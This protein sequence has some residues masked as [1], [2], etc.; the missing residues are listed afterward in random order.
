M[1]KEKVGFIF[2]CGRDGADYQVCKHLLGRLNPNI[3]MEASF[4]DNTERLLT[5]CGDVAGLLLKTCTRVVVIWDLEP[6]WDRTRRPCRHD[7]RECVFHSLKSAG[8]PKSKV[9]LLCIE[10]ELESWL[11]ADT[12]ALTSVLAKL[13]HPHSVNRLPRHSNPDTV[14][15]PKA[16]LISLFQQEA[17]CKYVDRY[18]ALRIATAIQ[19]WSRLKRS[20]SFRRFAERAARVSI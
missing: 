5:E 6:P 19:D 16:F 14:K 9:S 4:L 17:G 12:R 13:K 20:V 2:E 11:L 15:R 8:V 10:C 7:D 1:A 3:E 18:H